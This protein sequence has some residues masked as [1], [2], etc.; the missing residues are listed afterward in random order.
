ML[1]SKLPI[2]KLLIL[3]TNY[4]VTN[5][6]NSK[7]RK[8]FD[9]ILT[10]LSS[11]M[12]SS[13]VFLPVTQKLFICVRDAWNQLGKMSSESA[14]AAYVDEM[15]KVAQEVHLFYTCKEANSHKLIRGFPN[16]LLLFSCFFFSCYKGRIWCFMS[17]RQENCIINTFPKTIWKHW[18]LPSNPSKVIAYT[19]VIYQNNSN[20]CSYLKIKCKTDK[21]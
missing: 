8:H 20:E 19:T 11:D 14:M 2:L 4:K 5:N 7:V 1:L 9:K 21:N 13:S 17:N 12:L 3:S 10:T 6:C 15:K 16:S 18:N